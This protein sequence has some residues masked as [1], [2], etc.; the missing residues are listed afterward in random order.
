[1]SPPGQPP[2][3]AEPSVPPS[4]LVLTLLEVAKHNPED[5]TSRLALADW[6]AEHD[7]PQR[8]DF[9]RLQCPLGPASAPLVTDERVLQQARCQALLE[10]H[11]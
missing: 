11:G 10:Q 5:D 8:T 7:Q 3:C 1:M 4:P 2:G 9:I 6:L